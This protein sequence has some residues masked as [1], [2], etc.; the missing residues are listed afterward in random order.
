M[1]REEKPAT[2]GNATIA[3]IRERLKAFE[4]L[5]EDEVADICAMLRALKQKN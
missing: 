1:H 3:M 2:V 5:T 4:Q